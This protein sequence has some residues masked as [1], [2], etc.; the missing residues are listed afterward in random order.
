MA[1]TIRVKADELRSRVRTRVGEIRGGSSS[2]G[3]LGNPGVLKSPLVT[4]IKAKGLM[5][6]ARTR[7]EKIRGGGGILSEPSSIGEKVAVEKNSGA[8]KVQRRGLAIEA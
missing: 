3:I 1:E 8:L 5:A 2:G 6:T 7:L 4:E